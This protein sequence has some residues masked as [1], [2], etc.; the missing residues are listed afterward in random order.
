MFLEIHA[1]PK[2]YDEPTDTPIGSVKV[3]VDGSSK[4]NPGM[5]GARVLSQDDKGSWLIGFRTKEDG[6]QH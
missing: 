3:N 5:A 2:L 4:G 6:L 1:I